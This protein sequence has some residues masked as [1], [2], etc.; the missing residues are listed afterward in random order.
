MQNENDNKKPVAWDDVIDKAK[1]RNEIGKRV[2]GLKPLVK[3]LVGAVN[4]FDDHPSIANGSR[5][6]EVR[7]ELH[8]AIREAAEDIFAE[9]DMPTEELG[10]ILDELHI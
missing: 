9:W 6:Q 7:D 5:L 10:K 8:N 1:V 4:K 2:E 3:E